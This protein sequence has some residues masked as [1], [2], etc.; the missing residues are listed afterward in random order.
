MLDFGAGGL[1]G[2]CAVVRITVPGWEVGRVRSI[3]RDTQGDPSGAVAAARSSSMRF[4]LG[5]VPMVSGI[6]VRDDRSPR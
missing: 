3:A 1:A 2:L 5:R 6:A 4:P